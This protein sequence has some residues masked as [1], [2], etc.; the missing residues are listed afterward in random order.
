MSG[1]WT[2]VI[3]G[4]SVCHGL[5]EIKKFNKT[6]NK[7]LQVTSATTTTTSKCFLSSQMRSQSMPCYISS[8]ENHYLPLNLS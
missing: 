7:T 5:V 6:C 3:R 2:Q 8:S 4:V 1:T